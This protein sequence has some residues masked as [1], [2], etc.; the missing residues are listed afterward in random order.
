MCIRAKYHKRR[1]E[2]S[3]KLGTG[4]IEW[5]LFEVNRSTGLVGI[6]LG[7]ECINRAVLSIQ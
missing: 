3:R 6:F 5:N 7:A 2:T 1:T 4:I